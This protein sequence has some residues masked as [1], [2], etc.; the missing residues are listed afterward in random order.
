VL[1]SVLR[2]IF[3]HAIPKT[4]RDLGFASRS[5]SI[6]L[7]PVF[8]ENTKPRGAV[9]YERAEPEESREKRLKSGFLG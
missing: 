8:K 4:G 3:Y 6:H 7:A 5:E 1:N 2:A 9:K